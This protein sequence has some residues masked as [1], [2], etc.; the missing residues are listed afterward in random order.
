MYK[1]TPFKIFFLV[2]RHNVSDSKNSWSPSTD[3]QGMSGS[4]IKIHVF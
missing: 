1:E 3:L 4:V 2:S